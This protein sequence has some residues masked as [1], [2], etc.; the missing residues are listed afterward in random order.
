MKTLHLTSKLENYNNVREALKKQG[1][2]LIK[3]FFTKREI[4]LII[5]PV[6]KVLCHSGK[7]A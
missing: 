7:C 4:C 3:N 2:V 6:I 5:N 1:Y